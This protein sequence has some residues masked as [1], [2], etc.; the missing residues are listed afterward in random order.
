MIT[1]EDA[2]KLVQVG[3][4]A[5]KYIELGL[6]DSVGFALAEDI[7][8]PID[9][10]SFD[11]SAMDGYGLNA[12][13]D[14]NG[15]EYLLV[16]EQQ[17]GADEFKGVLQKNE[18]VRIFTGAKVPAGVNTV[19]QQESVV[20]N[21]NTV[22]IIGNSITV[23]ANIRRMGSQ[24]KKGELALKKGTSLSAASV[25][26]L[27]GFGFEKVKVHQKPRIIILNTGK[28]LI[29]P[30]TI[31][32]AG[33][34]YE[35]N[36]YS[37]NHALKQ[38]HIEPIEIS[39]VDDIKEILVQ[40]IKN[41]LKNCDILMI[42]GGVSVGDYDF[43]VDA[44]H[45]NGVRKIFHKIKQKP[46]KPLYFGKKENTLIFGLPG[47]PASTLTCFYQYV[48]PCIRKMLGFS[49]NQLKSLQLI[50]LD[51]YEKKAGLTHFLMGQIREEGFALLKHQESYKMNSYAEADA[52]VEIEAEKTSVQKGDLVKV[53]LLPS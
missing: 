41:S 1:V 31:G 13:S 8:A 10:P 50:C 36:S 21:G 48:L 24:T 42:T 17:T 12:D 34:I 11:Q 49:Q 2:R 40:K 22:A 9:F 35:S 37:L 18:T 32:D 25:S 38:M 53:Y 19:I 27:A 15:I 28:E 5:L 45:E 47:N 16:G 14:S 26:L 44:L 6:R 4:S 30:G 51:N 29:P 46:G 23:G 3:T 39:W 52:L 43:V 33:K 20:R 7:F